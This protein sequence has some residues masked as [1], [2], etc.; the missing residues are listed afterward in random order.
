MF[1][2]RELLAYVKVVQHSLHA[3]TKNIYGQLNFVPIRKM[4][5]GWGVC[6][7][8]MCVCFLRVVFV[9]D[10]NSNISLTLQKILCHIAVQGFFTSNISMLFYLISVPVPFYRKWVDYLFENDVFT[11]MPILSWNKILFTSQQRLG[12][13]YPDSVAHLTLSNSTHTH[14]HTDTLI[15]KNM[16][17]DTHLHTNVSMQII[18]QMHT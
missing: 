8:Q 12:V 17:T 4:C 14:T 15:K 7:D 5:S 3:T 2:F 6:M 11:C 9:C 1:L 16:H 13:F 18:R 10:R